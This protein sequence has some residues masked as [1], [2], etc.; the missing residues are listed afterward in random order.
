[1]AVGGGEAEARKAVRR[2]L[3]FSRLDLLVSN[4]LKVAPP[5]VV[6]QY[7]SV[8]TGVIGADEDGHRCF[9][10]FQKRKVGSQNHD[11]YGRHSE[12]KSTATPLA[13][14]ENETPAGIIVYLFRAPV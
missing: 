9:C 5:R 10:G 4:E 7:A 3:R 11:Q 13:L 2:R 12:S 1:M 8:S 14:I 6:R